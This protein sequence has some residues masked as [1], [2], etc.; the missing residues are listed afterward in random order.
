MEDKIKELE[1]RME[2]KEREERR[3]N[4]IIRALEVKEGRRREAVEE[5]LSVIGVRGN[6]EEVKR[7]RGRKRK[8]GRWFWLG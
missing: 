5:V 1:R 2:R 8:T 6:I 4:V 7:V 3:K